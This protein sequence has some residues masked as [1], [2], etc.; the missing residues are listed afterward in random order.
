M[1]STPCVS[2]IIPCYRQAHYLPEAVAS[3][4]AQT[5]G[6]WEI[7]IVDDG[8]PDDTAAVAEEL[9]ARHP[10]RAITLMRQK[11]QGLAAARNNGILRSRGRYILPLDA[12]D[13]IEP[14]MLAVTVAALDAHPRVGFVYTDVRRFGAEENVLRSEAYSRD[15]LRFECL[16]MPATLFRRAAWE[17]TGGFADMGVQGYEDWDFWLC[18]AEAGW[19]GLHLPEVLLRYRRSPSSMLTEAR[20]YDLELRARIVLNHPALYEQDLRAWAARVLSPAWSVRDRLRSPVHWVA[21]LLW[22]SVLIARY[23]PGLL[24][25]VLLRPI[26]WRLPVRRQGVARRLARL[27]RLSR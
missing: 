2:V 7:V 27:A 24:P 21:A 11:N 5:F 26:F 18:L 15:V 10:G 3:V 9:I 16:M 22:Y 1:S 19:E 17:Q 14:D 13:A 25:K 6:D 8:S 12:D 4:V 20:K 23:R